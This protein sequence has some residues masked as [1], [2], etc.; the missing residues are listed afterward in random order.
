[1]NINTALN[2]GLKEGDTIELESDKG[3]KVQGVLHLRKGQHPETVAIMGTAGHWAA[4][5]PIARGKGVNFNSLMAS[6][7]TDC[8]PITLNLELTVKVRITRIN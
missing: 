4:G 1:M 7:W 2:K 8:D 6:R 5:Q 3:N